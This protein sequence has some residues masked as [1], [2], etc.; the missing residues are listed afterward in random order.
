M[1]IVI[2]K[3]IQMIKFS[4]YLAWSRILLK[5]YLC[6]GDDRFKCLPLS[7]KVRDLKPSTKIYAYY[8]WTIKTM[9]KLAEILPKLRD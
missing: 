1:Y 5:K 2:Y 6:V 7:C 3:C 8:I 9:R 4:K